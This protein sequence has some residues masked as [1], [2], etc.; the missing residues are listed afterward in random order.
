MPRIP[1]EMVAI[2]ADKILG[3]ILS[4]KDPDKISMYYDQ[5][6]DYLKAT[7]WTDEEFD[8]ETSKRVDRGWEKTFPKPEFN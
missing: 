6:L 7:G 3:K 5:Y 4:T 1:Y 2:E 8:R